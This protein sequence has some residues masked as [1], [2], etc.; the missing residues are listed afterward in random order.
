MGGM[1]EAVSGFVWVPLDAIAQKMQ[2]QGPS[3]VAGVH[4]YH[5]V[6]GTFFK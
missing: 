6:F 3:P 4:K 1:A 5:G 2:I